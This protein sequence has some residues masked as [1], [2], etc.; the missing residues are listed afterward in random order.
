MRQ[1]LF[2]IPHEVVGLPV[3]GMGWA[4]IV[5]AVASA[6]LLW[7]LV[8][9][10]GWN[11][12]T[13][14]YLP[15]L[16][17]VAAA[18]YFVLPF[19]EER[20]AAGAPLGLAIRGYGV[21]LLVAVI[22]GVGLA[23]QQARRMGLDPELIYSLALWSFVGGIIGARAFFVIQYWHQFDRPTV[24]ATFGALLNVTQGG[25][26]VYGSLIGA[27][28]TGI[29]FIRKHGL[30]LLAVVD[31]VAPSMALGMAVGRIG[32]LLNGCCHG[33]LC[34]NPTLG[35]T[36]PRGSPPYIQQQLDGFSIGRSPDGS[37][38]VTAI[39]PNGPA[40]QGGLTVEAVIKSINE[41]PVD[42]YDVARGV[43][44]TS[45]PELTI[46]TDV[47]TA[48]VRAPPRSRPVHPT[49]IYSAISAAVLCLLL[50]AYYPFRR[51]D[52]EVM[53][54]LLTLYPITRFLL[55]IIR[56]DEPGRFGTPLTI[57]QLISLVIFAGACV[58]WRHLAR[59]PRGSVLPAVEGD[60]DMATA[61]G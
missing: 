45:G 3:F 35:M 9:R 36:F 56:N 60:D 39:E 49:Q 8:R 48:Q 22:C 57:S 10:Q 4:L 50:W 17:L 54:L 2:H 6:M 12:D 23:V 5:W 47:G 32:C 29:W 43:L 11:A 26:V 37:A 41:I 53:A 16:L 52:G 58:L 34:E 61:I 1:T 38:V 15:L 30:P 7:W 21:M 59:Q 44:A 46:E 51:R 31:L 14:S 20:S 13:R 18:F 42:S 33:G 27:G 40:E 55:E 19:L 25:L 28:I 24:G